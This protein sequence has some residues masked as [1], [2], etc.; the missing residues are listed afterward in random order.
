MASDKRHSS[1][2]GPAYLIAGTDEAKLDAA[3]ERLRSR[4]R[5]EGGPAALESFAPAPGSSAGPDAEGL[6][7]AIPA[8]S[9]TAQHRYL[10]ADGVE[11]WS[12]KQATAVAQAVGNLPPDVTV[13]LVAR[14]QPPRH[15]VPKKLADAV[16]AAGGEVVSYAAP[17]ARELPRW[18]A[19]AAR[20]RGFELESEAAQLLADR[21]GE[22]TTRLAS[23]LD[24][25][26]VWAEP[27]AAVTRADLEAMVADT[28]EEVAWA[29]SDAI[30]DR[31]PAAAVE[32]AE[33]LSE[34]GEAVT[35]MIYQAAKR[36]R[37]A[38]GALEQLEAGRPPKD[39]ESALPMHPYAAKLLVR[40]VRGRSR[41]QLRAATCAIAD[42]EWWTR[43][44]SD[45]PDRLALTLAVRRAAGG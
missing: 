5:A 44:G 15:R 26:A 36:L 1:Q 27:G 14:E 19:D 30:V 25:L 2:I 6:L 37:E 18:L 28:S 16:S 13:V 17:K 45:Y 21:L 11:R 33:R 34:Q 24:R 10:V 39:V 32:A 12:A 3:L 8:L 29:L 9:L 31:D 22:S 38:N 40:R 23:E 35:P 41:A 7:A 20:R 43:G 4:A 42:L